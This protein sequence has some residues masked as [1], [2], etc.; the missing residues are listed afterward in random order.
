MI[1][2]HHILSQETPLYGGNGWLELKQ[3]CSISDGDTS[4]STELSFPAHSGTHIDAPYHF[5]REWFSLDRFHPDLLLCKSPFLIEYSVQPGEIITL[6]SLLPLLRK[7]PVETD[8]LLIRSG[9]ET[10][11]RS[12]PGTYFFHGAWLVP[13]IGLWLRK[14]RKLKMIGFDWI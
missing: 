2:L 7:V 4:N 9:I 13:E 14:N 8:L 11:R 3:I 1:A 12:E 10:L 6:T 5:D